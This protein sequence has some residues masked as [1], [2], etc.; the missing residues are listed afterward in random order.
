M[1]K[2]LVLFLSLSLVFVVSG[3]S[4]YEA[5]LTEIETKLAEIDVLEAKIAEL[6]TAGT[7]KDGE[8]AALQAQIDKLMDKNFDEI[9]LMHTNDVHGTAKY[10]KYR[11]MGMAT[12]A[13]MV[14][15]VRDE[16]AY[17]YLVDAGDHFHGTTFATLEQGGSMVEVMNAVG[18]DLMVPGNHDFDYGLDRFLELQAMATF[19]MIS[20]NIEYK[21]DNAD[22]M[23]AYVIEDFGGVK[24]GFFGLTSPETSYKTHPDNVAL[25][26]FTNPI[27]EA[28][29]I[30]AEL[31]PL[32]DVVVLVAH[33]GLDDSTEITTEDIALAVEGIDVIID[34]HSHSYLPE[35]MVVNDTLIASAGQYGKYLGGVSISV[36]EGDVEASVVTFD[37][38]VAEDIYVKTLID[39]ISLGQEEIL[40]EVVGSAGEFLNGTRDFVRTGETNLGMLIT[41]AMIEVTGADVAFTNGGGI[42]ADIQAGEVTVGDIISVLPFGNIIVT[43]ELTGQE[44][45]DVLEYGTSSAPDASGKFPHVAGITYTLDLTAEAGSRVSNLQIGGVDVDLEAIYVVATNDFLKAG[46]DGYDL[47]A[48]K[49]AVG[50]F[51]GL[52]E[53]LEMMFKAVEGDV[54]LPTN[55]RLTIIE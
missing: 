54:V 27:D 25:L 23:D 32:V 14:S 44:L 36:T 34:G 48:E 12:I 6:E 40:N 5:K 46:G 3:C 43:I 26:N 49:D 28:T 55:K 2:L 39:F 9:I 10:D 8:I 35:G 42:R 53:A 24:V 47:F 16:Y 20:G 29:A 18:Y 52:H 50:E 30:M 17:S 1:K 19:P 4:N 45:L 37:S 33:I 38:N 21:A 7:A 22:L 15:N 31:E 11:G 51:M 41:D 13:T